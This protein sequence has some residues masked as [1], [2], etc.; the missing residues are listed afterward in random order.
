[1]TP[2][3][4]PKDWYT[5]DEIEYWLGATGYQQVDAEWLSTHLNHAYRKGVSHGRTNA[6]DTIERLQ[7][8]LNVS[9]ALRRQEVE[10]EQKFRRGAER[11]R[12]EAVGELLGVKQ[13]VDSLR[14]DAERY[15]WLRDKCGETK[16]LLDGPH[17][18]MVQIAF[19][20]WGESHDDAIDSYKG[21]RY[22]P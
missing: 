9:E 3:E 19:G 6:A 16:R 1:M 7:E 22:F 11:Q 21:G 17:G 8:A 15:Q 13:Q 2:E 20:A 12:D 10:D 5:T 4:H 18:I 14:A